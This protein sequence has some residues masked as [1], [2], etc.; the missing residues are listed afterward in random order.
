MSDIEKRQKSK[1]HTAY[2]V[3]DGVRVPSVT[4]IL[5]I[6]NKPALLQWAWRCG[7]EGIDYNTI[8]DTSADIGTLAHYLVMCHLTGQQAETNEYAIADLSLASNILERFVSWE[9]QHKLE[10]VLVEKPLVSEEF[11]YGGTI[12]WYGILDDKP[13]LLDLKTS[14]GIYP[15]YLYQLAAYGSLLREQGFDIEEY[16]ILRVGKDEDGHEEI[17]RDDLE[18]E[19][20]IFMA[21]HT[22]YRLQHPK[23]GGA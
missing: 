23:K 21:C 2:K 11:R 9:S 1:A 15:E 4:T 8:R 5:G 13:T 16:R 10:T 3:S 17:K 20:A 6:L 18:T 12:D 19:W 22:I 14:G 7:M